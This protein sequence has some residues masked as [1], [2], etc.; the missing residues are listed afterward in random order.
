LNSLKDNQR[1][2]KLTVI[3]YLN[4]LVPD[5]FGEQEGELVGKGCLRVHLDDEIIDVLPRRGR[6]VIFLSEVLEHEVR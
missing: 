3:T 6:S 5:E 2:R 1:L 4:T